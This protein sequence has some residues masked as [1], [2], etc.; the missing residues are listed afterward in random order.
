MTASLSDSPSGM[1]L[2]VLSK[3]REWFPAWLVAQGSSTVV[4]VKPRTSV[5]GLDSGVFRGHGRSGLWSR[6]TGHGVRS[7]SGLE[8]WQVACSSMMQGRD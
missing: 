3:E 7:V 1:S 5:G 4:G 8:P 2:Q 6:W